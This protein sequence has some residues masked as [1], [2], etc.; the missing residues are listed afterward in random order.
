MK[1]GVVFD[2]LN[3]LSGI[4]PS[5]KANLKKIRI[6]KIEICLSMLLRIILSI[7]G[8]SFRH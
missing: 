8:G 3:S 7:S 5:I 2:D 4:V 6:V 1:T